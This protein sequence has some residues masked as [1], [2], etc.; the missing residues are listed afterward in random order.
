MKIMLGYRELLWPG[1]E[2]FMRKGSKP[3]AMLQDPG[4][5]AHSIFL[6]M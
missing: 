6:I 5:E 2:N 3:S 1:E 4:G